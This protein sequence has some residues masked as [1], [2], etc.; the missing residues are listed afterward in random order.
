MWVGLLVCDS[1]CD[2]WSDGSTTNTARPLLGGSKIDQGKVERSAIDVDCLQLADLAEM[3][4]L[5]YL[6]L[7]NNRITTLPSCCFAGWTNMECLWLDCN[8]LTTLPN[9]TIKHMAGTL[10]ELHL[11]GNQLNTLPIE[12]ALL[13]QLNILTLQDNH[14]V[15]LPPQLGVL[16]KL[17]KIE[18]GKQ[19]GNLRFLLLSLLSSLLPWRFTC[20]PHFSCK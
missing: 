4:K 5:R 3:T 7:V 20:S 1:D 19:N 10:R 16:S 8:K 9:H 2:P 11:S 12:L 6:N 17:S 18:V 13:T 14:L 15:E